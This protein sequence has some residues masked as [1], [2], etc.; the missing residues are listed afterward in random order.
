MFNVLNSV[1]P[2]SWSLSSSVNI[3]T[4]LRARRSEFY[5]R[6]GRNILFA[7]TSRPA[8]AHPTPYPIDTAVISYG[9]KQPKR[10]DDHSPPCSTCVK[11][12]LS[13]TSTPPYLRMALC[14]VEHRSKLHPALDEFNKIWC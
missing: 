7:T 3:V 11:N 8:A 1:T 5:C 6:Q 2:Q 14:L 12:A 9:I 4:R 13:N 10:E